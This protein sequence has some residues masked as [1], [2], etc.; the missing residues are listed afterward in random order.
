MNRDHLVLPAGL[1][2]IALSI[3]IVVMILTTYPRANCTG[4]GLD[5]R[6]VS[7]PCRLP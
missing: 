1:A 2:V 7:V 5:G 6:Q 3:S 4:Y